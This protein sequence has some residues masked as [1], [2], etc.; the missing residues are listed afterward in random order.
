[1][2]NQ[3]G[4]SR[5]SADNKARHVSFEYLFFDQRGFENGTEKSRNNFIAIIMQS[6]SILLKMVGWATMHEWGCPLLCV[7][8]ATPR[9]HGSKANH[10][11]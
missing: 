5:H 11:K 6:F 8:L 7:E 1:M 4:N 2:V 3:F 9:V 10:L